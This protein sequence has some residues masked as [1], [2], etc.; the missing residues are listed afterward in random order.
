VVVRRGEEVVGGG[1]WAA[2]STV[3]ERH[4]REL[5]S[6]HSRSCFLLTV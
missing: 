1:G 5:M 6:L 4:E 2:F 3:G